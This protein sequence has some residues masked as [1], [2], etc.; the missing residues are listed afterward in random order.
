MGSASGRPPV[1]PLSA[2]RR[3]TPRPRSASLRLGAA[4]ADLVE[5]GVGDLT[6]SGEELAGR[7]S[8]VTPAAEENVALAGSRLLVRS[9]RFDPEARK[10]AC[11]GG[12]AG[13]R[14]PSPGTLA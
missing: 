4:R 6:G 12:A 7:R 9:R 11:R 8:C 3:M 1:S 5:A 10:V 2:L 13:P 14:D